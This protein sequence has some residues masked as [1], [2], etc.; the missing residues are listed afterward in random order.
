MTASA[1]ARPGFASSPSDLDQPPHRPAAT[2]SG[3]RA[4]SSL[5]RS[6]AWL[7]ALKRLPLS[8]WHATLAEERNTYTRLRSQHSRQP[9][10]VWIDRLRS[11]GEEL[12]EGGTLV[13]HSSAHPLGDEE[14]SPWKT[15]YTSLETLNQIE[16]DVDRMAGS[17]TD[18]GRRV[19][20]MRILH[21]WSQQHPEVSYRQ[22]MHELAA[23]VFEV[24]RQDALS[25]RHPSLDAAWQEHDT[26]IIF[27]GMM[28][29]WASL[30]ATPS[31]ARETAMTRHISRIRGSL[32]Q[33][34]P[35]L[36]AHL[37]EIG[38]EMQIFALRWLRLLFS[39]ELA[40]ASL[41]LLWDELIAHADD[42]ALLDWVC[43]AIL[44]RLRGQLLSADQSGAF[45]ALMRPLQS[46]SGSAGQQLH[47]P[48]SAG[49]IVE[50]AR[51][52][53]HA[54]TPATGVRCVLENRDRLGIATHTA[55]IPPA[56]GGEPV[57]HP[58]SMASTSRGPSAAIN[59]DVFSRAALNTAQKTAA[60]AY[61]NAAQGLIGPGS[62][63]PEPE[64]HG[65]PR[66]W[67]SEEARLSHRG[68]K[69]PNA[70]VMEAKVTRDA[71]RKLA[72]LIER[73]RLLGA[74][75]HSLWAEQNAQKREDIDTDRILEA[76]RRASRTLVEDVEDSSANAVLAPPETS[77]S[78]AV[79]PSPN[80][81]PS[82]PLH[83]PSL[84]RGFQ[85]LGTSDS[86]T[87]PP[88][89]ADNPLAI[90]Q[91]PTPESIPVHDPLGVA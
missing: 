90:A 36:S 70:P 76:L 1:S 63:L 71:S 47:D 64:S 34:D 8:Q 72:R 50:H 84:H 51:L 28:R 58:R 68:E 83:S 5:P 45:T 25:H 40:P 69:G 59:F 24:C 85:R 21:V 48:D 81:K 18:P 26:Y 89:R 42:E 39:R 79:L 52:L 32:A 31:P 23:V 4:L 82:D 78:P 19:C 10:G 16:M 75:L 38:I 43:V 13:Q 56:D 30:Y 41:L 55:T 88:R 61:A 33:V 3:P 6:L 91:P 27:D 17:S 20:I 73:D 77:Q 44:L 15:L 67:S 12:L 74:S 9:N 49:L 87:K 14:D 62:Q 60:W 66:G 22:G 65:Y 37:T 54:S 80:H 53:E 2:S 86:Q 7:H 29:R 57:T 46:A 11:E 35:A